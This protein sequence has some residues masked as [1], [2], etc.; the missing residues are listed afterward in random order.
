MHMIHRFVQCACKHAFKYYCIQIEIPTWMHTSKK[1]VN[2]LE[3][4][5][6]D[7]KHAC[8]YTCKQACKHTCKYA[9]K[10]NVINLP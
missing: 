9:C 6:V 7:T 5:P 2:I 10:R 8:K 1:D 3:N 4:M